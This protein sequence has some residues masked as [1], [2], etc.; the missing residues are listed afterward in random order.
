MA[1]LINC[2]SCHHELQVPDEL[3]GRVVKCPVCE[4]MFSTPATIEEAAP[5]VRTASP[6][7]ATPA[8]APTDKPLPGAEGFRCPFCQSTAKPLVREK[9]SVGGWVVF[10]VMLFMCF[11]LFWIGLLMKD[12]YHVCRTCGIQLS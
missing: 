8:K 2:P 5:D 11:P 10:A 6:D 12:T 1:N 3:L 4:R 7:T 9:I